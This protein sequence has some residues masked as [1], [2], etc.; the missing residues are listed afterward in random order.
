MKA[1]LAD[2]LASDPSQLQNMKNLFSTQET[3]HHRR[4]Y[5]FSMGLTLK[6]QE[7]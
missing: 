4:F 7:S 1:D 3:H 5:Q 2:F 6:I